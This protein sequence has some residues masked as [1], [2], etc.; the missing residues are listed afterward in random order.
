MYFGEKLHNIN[1]FGGEEKD[2]FGGEKNYTMFVIPVLQQ[3]SIF[4]AISLPT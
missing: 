2:A 3:F 1:I 4:Y